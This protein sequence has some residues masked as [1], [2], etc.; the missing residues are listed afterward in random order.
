MFRDLCSRD[1][2]R[3]DLSPQRKTLYCDAARRFV[4]LR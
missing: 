2:K 4:P 1:K 3:S